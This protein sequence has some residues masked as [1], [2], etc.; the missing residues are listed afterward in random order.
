MSEGAGRAYTRLVFTESV[1][2]VQAHHGTR[3]RCAHLESG[4]PP[5]VELNGQAVDLLSRARSLSL[6]TVGPDGWPYVQ[7][8]GG[9]AG[10]VKVLGPASLG[11]GDFDGNG[12]FVTIGNLLENPRVH[13]LVIDPATRE[14]LK[15][16]GRARVSAAPDM[17]SVLADAGY[18]AQPRRAILIDVEA[19]DFNCHRHLPG[20]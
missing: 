14:R 17:L 16:W 8:R 5:Q 6:A 3:E 15:L 20:R 19:W 7:H 13:L 9:P 12:Q 10:F 18:G 11:I 4:G 1:K 2:R